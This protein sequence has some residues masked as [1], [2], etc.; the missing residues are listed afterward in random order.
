MFIK[1]SKKNTAIITDKR[2]KISYVLL[3]KINRL[4]KNS[5]AKQTAVIPGNSNLISITSYLACLE[6]NNT[7]LIMIKIIQQ[8]T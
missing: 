6:S 3:K 7:C 2:K 1:Y 5:W 4:K 8:D